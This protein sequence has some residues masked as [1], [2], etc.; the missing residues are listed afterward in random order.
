MTF[1][2]TAFVYMACLVAMFMGVYLVKH[3][4]QHVQREVANTRAQ[5]VAE[6]ESLHLLKA[7]WAYLNRPDRLQ[8][9]AARHLDLTPMDSRQ[10]GDVALLPSV[11]REE[12]A[13]AVIERNP[14]VQPASQQIEDAE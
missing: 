6:R 12:N 5:L 7:E 13:V 11:R 1:R 3:N 2:L 4:V 8:R 14:M 10:I 9:L